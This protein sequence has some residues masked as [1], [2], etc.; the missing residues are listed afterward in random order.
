VAQHISSWQLRYPVG[1]D[2]VS[3]IKWRA[4]KADEEIVELGA[5]SDAD[6]KSRMKREFGLDV[7]L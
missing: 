6:Y 3:A 4:G 2:A 5:E 1:P 7:I